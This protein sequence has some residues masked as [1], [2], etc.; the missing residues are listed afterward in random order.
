MTSKRFCIY[1]RQSISRDA[2]ESLSIE[3]QVRACREYA[4]RNG[5]EVV[6]IYEDPDQK[7]WKLHRPAFD[8]MLKRI[9]QERDLTV[10]VFKLSR[11]ARDLMHQERIIGEIADAGGELASVTEPYIS[12]SPMVRQ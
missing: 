1:A 12:T 2:D 5:G 11:F 10:L 8:A 9:R 3:M 7:G 6:A 4:A